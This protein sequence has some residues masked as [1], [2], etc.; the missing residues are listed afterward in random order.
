MENEEQ[1]QES[2]DKTSEPSRLK[3]RTDEPVPNFYCG[4]CKQKIFLLPK[5]IIQC[6][7][8]GYRIIYK[9]RTKNHIQ[10]STN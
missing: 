8:C 2:E 10:Y 3:S 5:D 9:E 4:S 7:L 1:K 6:P